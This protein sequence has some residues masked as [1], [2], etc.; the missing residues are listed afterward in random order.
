MA[1]DTHKIEKATAQAAHGYRVSALELEL[2]EIKAK[3]KESE[4]LR[5]EYVKRERDYKNEIGRLRAELNT[6]TS[7]RRKDDEED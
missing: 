6:V 1:R 2:K 4:S 5:L 7:W 3:L